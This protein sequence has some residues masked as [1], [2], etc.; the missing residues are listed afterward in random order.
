M[1]SHKVH[2]MFMVYQPGPTA[3]PPI[4]LMPACSLQHQQPHL[5]QMEVEAAPAVEGLAQL[6]HEW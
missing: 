3:S 1:S 2:T 4:C 5:D 6:H